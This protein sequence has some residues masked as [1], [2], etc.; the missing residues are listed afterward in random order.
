MRALKVLSGLIPLVALLSVHTVCRATPD[1]VVSSQ[2]EALAI[3]KEIIAVNTAPSGGDDT[4]AAVDLL[5]QRLT[6][7]GFDREDVLTLAREPQHASLVVRYRSNAPKHPPLLMMAHLDVVE[8]LPEDWTVD[9]FTPTER[10]GFLYGRGSTDNKAGAAILVENFI[11]YRKEGMTPDRDLIVMLNTD[12]E[13]TG[14]NVQWLLSEHRNLIDAEFALNTDGGMVIAD[15][16]GKNP[17][18]FIVQTSEKVYVTYAVEATDPGGHSSRPRSDSAIYRIARVLTAL[19]DYRFPIDLNETTQQAFEQWSKLA[20]VSDRP[21]LAALA[22][23]GIGPDM[24]AALENSPYYNALARTTCVATMLEGGH[25]ENALPQRARAVI[26][27][28]VLPQA[29]VGTVERKLNELAAPF[30]VRISTVYAPVPSPLSALQPA[31]LNPVTQVARELWPG[32]P[33]IPEMSTGATDGLFLRNAGIPTYGVGA[34][35]KDPDDNRAHG[36]DE[37]IRISSFYKSLEYWYRLVKRFS[38]AEY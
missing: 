32:I 8:A 36:R 37:R 30:D 33:V 19:Q 31:V 7:A 38:G 26:N 13:T 23:G 29:D 4:R 16:M 27:C 10:D 2:Q 3:L 6:D 20:P 1:P 21:L 18:A 9:P 12:E 25:A 11:R 34:V 17:T 22:R 14:D 5:A 15:A 24:E 35:E 28:R